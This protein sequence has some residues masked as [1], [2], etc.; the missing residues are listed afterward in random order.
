MPD[1]AQFCARSG[2]IYFMKTLI[3]EN[4]T[5]IKIWFVYVFL[6]TIIPFLLYFLGLSILE[7]NIRTY[8][9]DFWGFYWD[10][11]HY[12]KIATKGYEFPLFAFFPGYPL[13]IK[14]LDY[15]L[16]LT[17]A[18]RVNILI[19]LLTIISLYKFM[20]LLDIARETKSKVLIL[21]LSYPTSFF[22]FANYVESLYILLSVWILYFLNK[23]NYLK[24][25][26]LTAFLSSIKISAVIIPLILFIKMISD[27]YLVFKFKKENITNFLKF[28]AF[29]TI[30]ILGIVL[31]FFY[32]DTF[33]GGFKIY[34]D[35]QATWG[36]GRFDMFINQFMV[37]PDFYFEKISEVLIF[38]LLCFIFIK[39][40]GNLKPHYFLFSLFHFLVPVLTGTLISINRLSLY[41][42][43]ILFIFFVDV[44]EK[45]RF[46]QLLIV[47][48]IIQIIGLYLFLNG[49]FIG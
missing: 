47:F 8:L 34:F 33:Y 21:F 14:F 35:S 1:L 15:F 39:Y 46:K 12:I 6:L 26:I 20:D 44:I 18:Y 13:L 31:Y 37:T 23:K 41:C 25:S 22:L 45:K 29:S 27:K 48:S 16:P 38:F 5:P 43:P 40:Y 19:S 30:S 11:M 9:L 3:K 17:V 2:I 4:L 28:A 36:R 7:F 42:F 24:V 32:L 49:K 10:G